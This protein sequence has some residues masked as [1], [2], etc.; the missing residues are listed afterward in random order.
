MHRDLK[1][2][3]IMIRPDG[4]VKILDFGLAKFTAET[5]GMIGEDVETQVAAFEGRPRP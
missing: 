5:V 3:N 2:A 1:P 4:Q